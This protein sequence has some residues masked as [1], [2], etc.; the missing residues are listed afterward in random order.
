MVDVFIPMFWLVDGSNSFVQAA[1]VAFYSKSSNLG[2]VR[3]VFD[4]MPQRSLV[5]WNSMISGYEQNGLAKEAIT[6]FNQM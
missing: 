4:K 3:L 2:V 1:L 6:L 5:A